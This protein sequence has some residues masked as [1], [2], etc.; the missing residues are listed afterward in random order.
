M[1]LDDEHPRLAG[2]SN[3]ELLD[4]WIFSGNENPIQ[5][6]YVAGQKV[7][8]GGHHNRETEIAARY[9]RTLAELASD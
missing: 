9:A 3:N 7:V 6:V 2:R 8:E 1:V 5:D 4:S